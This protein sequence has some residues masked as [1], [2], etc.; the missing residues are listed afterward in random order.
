MAKNVTS[1]RINA[2]RVIQWGAFVVG[3]FYVSRMRLPP[4]G[5]AGIVQRRWKAGRRQQPT[6]MTTRRDATSRLLHR[7]STISWH[8]GVASSPWNPRGN[9]P[10]AVVRRSIRG[11]AGHLPMVSLRHMLF[12]HSHPAFPPPPRN[13]AIFHRLRV[14]NVS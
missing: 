7:E 8:Y 10:T 14:N 3:S 12:P 4:L 1:K 11:H 5:K 13:S 2:S 9:A 6:S